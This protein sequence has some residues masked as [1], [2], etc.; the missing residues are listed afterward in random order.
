M[1]KP[2]IIP[3]YEQKSEPAIR[4]HWIHDTTL[5]QPQL[6]LHPTK[7]FLVA[8]LEKEKVAESDSCCVL[9]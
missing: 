9:G 2:K 8:F 6:N 5:I 3:Q 4:K 7:V 1:I